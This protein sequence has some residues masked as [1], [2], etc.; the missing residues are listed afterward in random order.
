[1]DTFKF[2]TKNYNSILTT[3][4][5]NTNDQDFTAQLTS[6]KSLNPDVIFAPGNYTE[7]ALLISQA[8]QLGINT[9]FIGGDTW[10]APEFLD[11]GKEYQGTSYLI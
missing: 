7:S 4:N 3:L 9:P 8:R 5:Y 11:V 1:M 10:E 6:I 2:G